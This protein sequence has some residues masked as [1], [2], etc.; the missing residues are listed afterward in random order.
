MCA[1]HVLPLWDALVDFFVRH[2]RSAN[3]KLVSYLEMRMVA[4]ANMVDYAEDDEGG[5]LS[6]RNSDRVRRL[7]CEVTCALCSSKRKRAFADVRVHM[8]TA[9]PGNRVQAD[10]DRYFRRVFLD[11]DPDELSTAA[12][13]LC[14]ALT[15]EEADHERACF[16]IEYM[17]AYRGRC[18]VRSNFANIATVQQRDAAWLAWS[19]IV[20]ESS[21]RGGI[22]DRLIDSTLSLFTGMHYSVGAGRK[23]RHLLFFAA[24]LLTDGVAHMNTPII[25]DVDG[26]EDTCHR[27]DEIYAQVKSSEHAPQLY[28]YTNQEEDYME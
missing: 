16:W 26:M 28:M 3:P 9:M 27:I 8:Q 5:I 20:Y 24:E 22:V 10:S 19:A 13:E 1:G 21:R 7:I 25:G 11:G 18:A 15:R 12:N 23:R 14:F 17:M 2:I 4:L 6:L